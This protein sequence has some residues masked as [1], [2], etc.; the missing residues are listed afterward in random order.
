[1]DLATKVE[2]LIKLTTSL[3]QELEELRGKDGVN[4]NLDELEKEMAGLKSEI[5]E[6]KY[7][8]MKQNA[9][10]LALI[11]QLPRMRR[12]TVLGDVDANCPTEVQK[13]IQDYSKKFPIA[14]IA[15]LEEFEQ[16]MN[17]NNTTEIVLILERLLFHKGVVRN[18]GSVLS[19]QVIMACNLDGMHG[20]QRLLKY[21]KFVDALFQAVY[22]E[23]YGLKSF[24]NDL[25]RGLK[26]VKNRVFKKRSERNTM[27][28]RR[29]QLMDSDDEY[30]S[31]HCD[32]YEVDEDD[33]NQTE[34]TIKIEDSQTIC[35]D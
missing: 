25:R 15:D 2:E 17:D 21:T 32:E 30:D 18:I 19:T 6:L 16:S 10:I 14:T 26:I 23:G 3:K 31:N 11:H 9:K 28:P 22:V 4:A 29:N 34:S 20:K 24:H 27:K 12:K 35:G 5:N 13:K 7:C 1:M 33:S 8:L